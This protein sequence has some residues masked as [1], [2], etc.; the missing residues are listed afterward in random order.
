[1]KF[2]HDM[3]VHGINNQELNKSSCKHETSTLHK[4]AILTKGAYEKTGN[5]LLQ[6]T[7]PATYVPK[8]LFRRKRV[9]QTLSET[10]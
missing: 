1:M 9:F 5:V 3:L 6:E 4:E 7:R 10:P 8:K 2:Q